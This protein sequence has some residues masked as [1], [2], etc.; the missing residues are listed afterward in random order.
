MTFLP[1]VWADKSVFHVRFGGMRNT[2]TWSKSKSQI[3]RD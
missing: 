3:T 2:K 1:E